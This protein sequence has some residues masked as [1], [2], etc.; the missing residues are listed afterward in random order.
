MPYFTPCFFDF[1]K[2][3][4]ANN[5]KE[6]FHSHKKVYEDCVKN[7]TQQFVADVLLQLQSLDSRFAKLTVKDCV[8]R[9]NR[10]IRF[11]KDKSPY[12]LHVGMVFSPVGKKHKDYPGLYVELNPEYIRIYGGIYA[13]D[14]LVL[15]NVRKL[16]MKH[17][18]KFLSIINNPA[19]K[20]MYGEILGAKNKRLPKEMMDFAKKQPLI[21]NKQW[22]FFNE[23]TI[24]EAFSDN[25]PETIVRHYQTA[26]PFFDFFEKAVKK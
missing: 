8:F 18:K 20:T 7:P 13:P 14:K 16:L 11:S 9:I 19:F 22:Y 3:L 2:Q 21:M 23:L 12:K 10:D 4:A 26:L 5:H 24:P 15:L 17:P 25:F 6:W 1:F